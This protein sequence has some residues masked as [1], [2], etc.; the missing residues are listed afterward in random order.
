MS[1][2]RFPHLT[3]PSKAESNINVSK[4][5]P[6]S[7][8]ELSRQHATLELLIK[9]LDEEPIL[10]SQKDSLI[11]KY[12]TVLNSKDKRLRTTSLKVFNTEAEQHSLQLI[13][14]VST[15]VNETKL[16]MVNDTEILLN[17]PL[18]FFTDGKASSSH[19][20]CHSGSDLKLPPIKEWETS[21][22]QP[23]YSMFTVSAG[24]Q[25]IRKQKNRT[26]TTSPQSVL[27]KEKGVGDNLAELVKR[28]IATVTDQKK[29]CDQG[30]GEDP[31]ELNFSDISI[32][33]TP[34]E[35]KGVGDHILPQYRESTTQTLSTKDCSV[36]SETEL[37][38]YSEKATQTMDTVNVGTQM[39][40]MSSVDESHSSTVSPH[41]PET[42]GVVIE[43]SY[44]ENRSF[45]LRHQVNKVARQSS[46]MPNKKS[47]PVRLSTAHPNPRSV[48]QQLRRTSMYA[49]KQ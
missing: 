13:E 35:E 16:Y 6:Y 21:Y 18:A 3:P 20:R 15:T 12:L 33:T 5:Q 26:R 30:V 31:A 42:A 48:N 49:K 24:K 7:M 2:P 14:V 46:K 10:Q 40:Q 47:L 34:M 41:R 22:C 36:G 27:V 29:T 17:S 1:I 32:E 37:P 43:T 25:S 11:E 4:K 8:Q 9:I 39:E 28:D 38:S 44:K 19:R 23:V 45:V